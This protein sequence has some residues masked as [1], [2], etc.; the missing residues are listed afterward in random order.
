MCAW[1][2]THKKGGFVGF[3]FPSVRC[4]DISISS[5]AAAELLQRADEHIKAQPVQAGS[6]C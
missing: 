3:L 1:A 6:V 4:G 5:T 2:L